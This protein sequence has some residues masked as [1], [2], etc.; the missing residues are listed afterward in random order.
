[1]SEYKIRRVD[2]KM[3]GTVN[4]SKQ[5]VNLSKSEKVNLTKMAD[6]GLNNI[7]IGLGWDP[8]GE[9]KDAP[10]QKKG[11]F[12]RLFGGNGNTR[13]IANSQDIDCDAW[14]QTFYGDFV[15]DQLVYYGKLKYYE[16]G[17]PIIEHQGDNLTG[18]GDGDDEVINIYLDKLPSRVNKV[19]IG[20]T[21]YQAVS[22]HQ[23]FGMI[24][25][26]FIRIVDTRDGFEMCRYEGK[27]FSPDSYTFIAGFLERGQNGWEFTASGISTSDA[28]IQSAAM[29][30]KRYLK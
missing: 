27:E 26:A 23:S 2:E 18:E 6:T 3:S 30:L 19:A 5:T 17:Q 28:T 21:I 7:M 1:M 14:V 8:V 10:A 29:A 12:A 20:V 25:N 9:K 13:P 22:R 24:E 11:F 15:P 4:L 16:D